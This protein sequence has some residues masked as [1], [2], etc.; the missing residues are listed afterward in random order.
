M[1]SSGLMRPL[2]SIRWDAKRE[3]MSVDFPNPVW[4]V[5]YNMSRNSKQ[6]EDRLTNTDDVELETS[7]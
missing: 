7:L 1:D 5:A 6:D 2:E 4:P 3:L